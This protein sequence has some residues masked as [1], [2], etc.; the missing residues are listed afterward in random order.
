MK[1]SQKY[2]LLLLLLLLLPF[3]Q[4]LSSSVFPV[5]VRTYAQRCS[6]VSSSHFHI[7]LSDWFRRMTWLALQ[8]RRVEVVKMS[9]IGFSSSPDA[10]KY[11]FN[12]PQHSVLKHLK[13]HLSLTVT[14]RNLHPY[15]TTCVITTLYT[16][17]LQALPT[18]TLLDLI[19]L[20]IKVE[21][22]CEAP[23]YVM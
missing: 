22:N 10:C 21:L 18:L 15:K 5:L 14:D 6:I 11:C 3:I 16:R 20:T 9:Q 4:N 13:P 12:S 1:T 7:S 19:T 2:I 8:S 17:V 23:H